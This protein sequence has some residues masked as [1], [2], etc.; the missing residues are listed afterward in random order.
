MHVLELAI[1]LLTVYPTNDVH[2]MVLFPN[3]NLSTARSWGKKFNV[4]PKKSKYEIVHLYNEMTCS[5]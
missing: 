3:M 4:P 2:A 5:H 1:P